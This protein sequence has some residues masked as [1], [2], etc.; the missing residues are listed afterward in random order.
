VAQYVINTNFEVNVLNVGNY[1]CTLTRET[2]IPIA[3]TGSL[4][5][6]TPGSA[7]REGA[8]F[9][10]ATG[11]GIGFGRRL[12]GRFLIKGAGQLDCWLRFTNTNASLTETAVQTIVLTQG[13][14]SLVFGEMS[15][16][17]G[18]TVDQMEVLARTDDAIAAQAVTF[19]MDEG[20]IFE[21]TVA[22]TPPSVGGRGAGR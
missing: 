7:V 14:T 2:G 20:Y 17:A 13:V 1:G 3:G 16:E 9:L 15:V 10:T 18:K 6:V 19:Y 12:S 11:L 4:K 22:D 5:V 21:T 8:S